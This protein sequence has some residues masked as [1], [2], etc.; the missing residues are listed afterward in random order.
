MNIVFIHDVGNISMK[1]YSESLFYY[2]FALT[3]L[4]TYAKDL[5]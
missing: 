2:I 1:T 5:S 4:M 3:K